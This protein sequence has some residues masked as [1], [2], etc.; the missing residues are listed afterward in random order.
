MR[1][2]CGHQ[3]NSTGPSNFCPTA[4]ERSDKAVLT[5]LHQG[6]RVPWLIRLTR[7]CA[8]IWSRSPL[9]APDMH[10][11]V[12]E[13]GTICPVGMSSLHRRPLQAAPQRLPVM[14][15]LQCGGCLP[16]WL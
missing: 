10:S 6:V 3:A 11:F 9:A 4:A 12:A 7:L 15:H 2:G 8:D 1:L 16:C 14:P 5:A 13:L